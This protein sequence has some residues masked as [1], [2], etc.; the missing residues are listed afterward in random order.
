MANCTGKALEFSPLKRRTLQVDFGGGE[1]SS[2]GG[3]LLLRE[4]DRRL[5]LT[6]RVAAVLDDPRD[7]LA[8]EVLARHDNDAAVAEEIR[9][10]QNAPVPERHDGCPPARQHVVEVGDALGAPPPGP[11]ERRDERT[12]DRREIGRAHV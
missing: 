6:R 11:T 5:G 4:V 2:D 1:V 3:L 8:V 9:G 12:A 10:R 7:P